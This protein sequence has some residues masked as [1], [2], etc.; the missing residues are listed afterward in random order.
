MVKSG[1]NYPVSKA[2][3]PLKGGNVVHIQNK[4]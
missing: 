4:G 3:I 1:E 2:D